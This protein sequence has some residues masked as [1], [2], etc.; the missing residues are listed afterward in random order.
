MFFF[1]QLEN[2]NMFKL[3]SKGGYETKVM[4]GLIIW[5]IQKNVVVKT[6]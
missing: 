3:R 2:K 6:L 4:V 1:S 5:H